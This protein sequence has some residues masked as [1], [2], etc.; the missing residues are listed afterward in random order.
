MSVNATPAF[1]V[2]V[3]THGR[4]ASLRRCL[5]ALAAQTL[6][7]HEWTVV[8]V[9]DGSPEDVGQVVDTVR[10]RMK[11]DLIRQPRTGPAAARNAG[12]AAA[13]GR[14]L[15][16]TDDD[17]TPSPE[18]LAALA[19]EF[20]RS[21]DHML[22]GS[23]LNA[24]PRNPYSD[25]SQAVVSYLYEY[26]NRDGRVRFVTSNNMAAPTDRFRALG[27]FCEGFRLAAAE[28]RDF[29]ERWRH[30]GYAIQIVP[31]AVVE[32]HHVLGFRTFWQQ[33]FQYG[34]GA[35]GF[36][37]SRAARGSEA[38][39]IEPLGFYV[40]LL[41]YPFSRWRLLSGAHRVALMALT[42]VANAAGYFYEAAVRR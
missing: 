13:N 31:D 5:E 16:F 1:T 26:Y 25:V 18:W 24:V 9:D 8:V 2:V 20:G 39:G 30:A 15:A 27:G 10:A 35:H 34:R 40:G 41:R 6:P 4:A 28:D 33:H 3:P 29:C 19:R 22:G 14:Y 32:H 38:M 12:A 37:R 42:Q 36:H 7:R 21:P 11:V 17:C 23:T